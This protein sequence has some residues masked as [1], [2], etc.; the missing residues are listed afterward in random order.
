M[1]IIICSLNKRTRKRGT[2]KYTVIFTVLQML[3]IL[4]LFYIISD[5]NLKLFQITNNEGQP[6]KLYYRYLK[7]DE[8]SSSLFVG[9]M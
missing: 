5:L 6:E 7:I 1:L 9:A 2:H 4:L 3:F 8:T